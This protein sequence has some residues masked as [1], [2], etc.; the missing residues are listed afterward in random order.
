M[1]VSG[2]GNAMEGAILL[3]YGREDGRRTTVGEGRNHG[4]YM[5]GAAYGRREEGCL[6]G[7]GIC[8]GNISG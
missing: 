4:M 3:G 1:E 6:E 2:G 5:G 8:L 7:G